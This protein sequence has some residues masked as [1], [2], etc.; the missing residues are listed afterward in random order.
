[1]SEQSV[2]IHIEGM[3]CAACVARLEKALR[4]VDG[5]TAASVNLATEKAA[6]TYDPGAATPEQLIEAVEI[7]GFEGRVATEETEGIQEAENRRAAAQFARR[8]TAAVVLTAPLLALGMLWMHHPPL[9]VGILSLL[10]ATPVQF[11]CGYPFL[12]GAWKVLRHGSS[13]MNVLVAVGTLAAYGH[14]VAS[15]LTGGAHYYFESG[16]T[17]TTLVL[18]GRV[19]EARARGKVSEAVRRLIGLAPKTALIRRGDAWTEVAV[20][21][22]QVGDEISVRSGERIPADGIVVQGESSVDEAMITGES[23]PVRKVAGDHVIGGTVNLLGALVVRATRVGSDTTLAQ[24]VRLV[25]AAQTAKPPIQRLADAVAARFVPAVLLVAGGTFLWWVGVEGA[26]TAQA[27]WPTVAVLVIACPCALGLATPTAIMAATGRATELGLLIRNGEALERCAHVTTILLDKTGTLTEGRPVVKEVHSLA[28][29]DQDSVLAYAASAEQ[30]STHPM[31]EALLQAA[32]DRG[33]SLMP[34]ERF[35]EVPGHG[36]RAEVQGRTLG[37]G[38]VRWLTAEAGSL[39]DSWIASVSEDQAVIGVTMDGQWCGVVTVADTVVPSARQAIEQLQGLVRQVVM[40]TG[41]RREV[42]QSVAEQL[43]LQRVEASVKPEEKQEIV[44]RYQRQGERVA[45]VGDGI[46][47]APALA[48]ADVGIAVGRG[49]DVA[50]ETGDMVLM[51]RDLHGVSDA[52]LLG[53]KTLAIIR[54]NLFWAFV[55]NVV[56]I[57][58]AASGRLDPILAAA[59]MGLSSV[60]VVSNSLRLRRYGRGRREGQDKSR[61][62]RSQA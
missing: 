42:A 18:V 60:S 62:R 29:L 9:W 32:R 43:G 12:L 5:V 37:V 24:I 41:D 30:H 45:M 31:A 49:T 44:V 13:D 58:L 10:L 22:V 53:R 1:M 7:A 55:Y 57:P 26:S 8:L 51:R 48:Q 19:L 14:S 4:R 61:N 15:L 46:N 33:I 3:T 54:Q 52:V 16:A 23:W 38:D 6:V 56:G 27:V 39:D 20:E 25:E 59:A 34:L 11:Y 17:I 35:T 28:D 40:V 36:V 2:E 21:S 47:D 50:I